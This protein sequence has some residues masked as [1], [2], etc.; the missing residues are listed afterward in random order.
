MFLAYFAGEAIGTYY[1]F[2]GMVFRGEAEQLSQ[3]QCEFEC[4]GD[5][6]CGKLF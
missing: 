2:S 6:A 1:E 4:T 3:V 5:G